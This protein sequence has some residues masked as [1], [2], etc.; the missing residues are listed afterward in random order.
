MLCA[1][2]L[3]GGLNCRPAAGGGESSPSK[4]KSSSM[5][6]L[7]FRRLLLEGGLERDC[8]SVGSGDELRTE[9]GEAGYC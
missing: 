4:S 2:F 1:V 6:D 7:R 8:C 9:E 5:L 3:T